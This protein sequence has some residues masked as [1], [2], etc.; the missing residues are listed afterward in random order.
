M[1][2]VEVGFFAAFEGFPAATNLVEPHSS[3]E[4]VTGSSAPM[5][6]S[7]IVT[8][9]RTSLFS[10]SPV[11]PSSILDSHTSALDDDVASLGRS[12]ARLFNHNKYNLCILMLL[13]SLSR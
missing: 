9:L 3:G 8:V 10:S 6:D 5:P 7:V 11:W 12:E 4:N 1:I 13:L 2:L